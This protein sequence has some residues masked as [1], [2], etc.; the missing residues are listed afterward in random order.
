MQELISVRRMKVIYYPLIIFMVAECSSL[1][2][3]KPD[4]GKPNTYSS[5]DIIL[6]ASD[7]LDDIPRGHMFIDSRQ[8]GGDWLFN[9][10]ALQM[11]TRTNYVKKVN[12]PEAGTYHL[13]VRSKGRPGGSFR[14]AIGNKVIAEDL[15]DDSLKFEKAGVFELQAGMVDIRIMRIEGSPVLDVLALVKNEKFSEEDLKLRQGHPDVE[16]LKEYLIPDPFA[17]KFGDLDGDGKMDFL[18]LT[19]DYS[20]FAYNHAGENLWSWQAPVDGSELRGQFEAPGLVWDADRDGA[21]EAFH[22]RLIDGQEYIVAA[23]GKTGEIKKKTQWPTVNTQHVYNNFRLAAADLQGTGYPSNVIAFTD[24][25]DSINI[26]AYDSE[27]KMLWK[28]GR[29][30]KKDHMGHYV[31]TRDIDHDGKEEIL[32]GFIMLDDDGAERWDLSELFY[33]HHDHADSYTFADLDNDGNEEAIGVF[34][35]A[36]PAALNVL[37]GEILWQNVAEHAQQVEAGFFLKDIA[38][39]HIAVGARF[40]GNRR[41]GEAYLWSQ[42]HWFDSRGDL[43]RKWPANPLTGN[44]V[45]VKGDWNGDSAEELF[46]YKFRM[47]DEGRGILY[48]AEPVYHMFDFMGRGAEEIITIGEGKIR[49]YGYKHFQPGSSHDTR[50]A[51]YYKN[52]VA[53]HSHYGNG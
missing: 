13:F 9:N 4:E 35:D 36:G 2:D 38:G 19:R 10:T 27:L 20:A 40:Y 44:P 31:Y 25:G 46:W 48:F 7:L 8:A 3:Q 43:I 51:F 17:V 5:T 28:W 12:I 22:W 15:G 24:M 16:L 29:P 11:T 6:D 14:I 42:V 34:S 23:D 52:R 47:N 45:F 37:T 32:A 26:A 33:D 30:L 49:I 53:N 39:P 50:D 41:A 21:A 1:G 18:A